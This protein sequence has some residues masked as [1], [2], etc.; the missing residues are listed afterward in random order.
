MDA[1][2]VAEPE[3][4]RPLWTKLGHW[5]AL[6]WCPLPGSRPARS[7]GRLW[8]KADSAKPDLAHSSLSR[9]TIAERCGP[10]GR[11]L[12]SKSQAI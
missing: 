11:R 9:S 3:A 8:R 1:F 2:T 12:T 5:I 7:N 10:I 4:Y 6:Q